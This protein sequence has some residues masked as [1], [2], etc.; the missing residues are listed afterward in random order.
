MKTCSFEGV[1]G[2]RTVLITGASGLLG[3]ELVR[4]FHREG[5][6]VLA[7]YFEKPGNRGKG[8][9]WLQGDF[10]SSRHIDR[11]FHKFSGYIDNTTHLINNYG[12]LSIRSTG[13]LT[14]DDFLS[15][16]WGN[17]GVA[18][19]LFFHLLRRAKLE[20]VVNIGFLE[21]ENLRSYSQIFPYALAKNGLLFL[22]R[23]LS[24]RYSNISINMVSPATLSGATHARRSEKG[25][26]AEQVAR[27]VLN[28][29][30]GRKTGTN[31]RIF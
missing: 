26:P 2:N 14:G 5:F 21:A 6:F 17:T 9:V 12:P 10:S 23:S 13:S 30:C 11:F 31:F 3:R 22:T 25:I 7:H 4:T 15:H 18:A 29:I 20:A 16:F 28:V 8:I 27:K 24:K 1:P 19:A